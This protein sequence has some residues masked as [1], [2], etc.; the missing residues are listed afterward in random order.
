MTQ[1]FLEGTLSCKA[2]IEG[3]RRE[4]MVL[5]VD[6]K[7][8]TRDF[9]WIIRKA[10]EKNSPVI[11]TDRS[12][13]DAL[14]GS[15]SHGGM[16]LETVPLELK[17]VKDISAAG[18]ICYIEGVEDPHNLGSVCRTLYAAGCNLL[19]LPNRDRSTS[20]KVI[21]RAS[22]GTFERLNVAQTESEKALLDWLKENRIPLIAAERR[23]A[24]PLFGYVY[25]D[26]FCLAIGGA[27]RGLGKDIIAQ[28]NTRLYIPY[29]SDMRAALDTPS[30]AAVFAF[31]YAGEKYDQT[32]NQ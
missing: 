16:V 10:H 21:M 17:D 15:T 12:K 7:K 9:S 19:I 2:A 3:G 18:F 6:E 20:E 14:C 31:H 4:K 23:D 32:Q 11:K 30:A 13:L 25:P 24:R 27:L 28:A 8:H 29:L 5:Y 22:A 1:L 26:T